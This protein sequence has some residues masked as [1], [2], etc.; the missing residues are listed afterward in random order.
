MGE[1]LWEVFEFIPGNYF[2]GTEDELREVA[3]QIARLHAALRTIPFAEEIGTRAK[4]VKTWSVE[5]YARHFADAA[6]IDSPVGMA[7]LSDRAFLEAQIGDVV[8]NASRMS[9]ATK[10]VVRNSLHP[11]DVLFEDGRLQAIIDFEEI[12]INQLA[13]DVGN[14]CHR[15]VRQYVV[16]QGRP[17]SETLARCADIF[18]SAY[19]E[20]N[21]LSVVD[22]DL[23]SVFIKDELLRKLHSSLTKLKAAEWVG[24]YESETLKF[25]SL[26]KEASELAKIL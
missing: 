14:A 9:S 22:V 2:R 10:Q 4:T 25:I 21:P 12:G 8:Q 26:L 24:A 18:L 11:H 1:Y 23:L 5:D 19:Q 13:R 17:W 7:L 3:T 6:S 16:Y 15:F 20:Q